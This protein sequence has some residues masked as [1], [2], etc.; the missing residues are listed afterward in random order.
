M[1]LLR[2][3][4][5]RQRLCEQRRHVRGKLVPET[6][7]SAR[8]LSGRMLEARTLRTTVEPGSGAKGASTLCI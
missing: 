8:S 4:S 5:I 3:Y 6:R 7:L 1:R 2:L